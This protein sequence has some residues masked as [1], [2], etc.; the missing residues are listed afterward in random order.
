MEVWMATLLLIAVLLEA[1]VCSLSTVPGVSAQGLWP[2]HTDRLWL[3]TLSQYELCTD[4]V[5]LWKIW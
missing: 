5:P 3:C 4:R 2:I 1:L